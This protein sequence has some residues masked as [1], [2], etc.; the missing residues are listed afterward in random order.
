MITTILL[1]SAIYEGSAAASFPT[2]TYHEMIATCC[3][4]T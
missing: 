2:F 3:S 4:C 1:W